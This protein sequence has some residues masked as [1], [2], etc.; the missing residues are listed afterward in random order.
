[1][2][3][4]ITPKY[5]FKSYESLIT[6]NTTLPNQP[7]ITDSSSYEPMMTDHSNKKNKMKLT[8]TSNITSKKLI[9]SKPNS[10]SSLYNESFDKTSKSFEK[11]I[12][13]IKHANSFHN[14]AVS[15]RYLEKATL[16]SDVKKLSTFMNLNRIESSTMTMLSKGIMREKDILQYK[17]NVSYLII[18][19]I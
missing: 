5:N 10:L 6:D 11:M 16:E 17:T 14:N 13:V 1:M 9:E 2:K 4:D 15:A 19:I 7:M 8:K 12:K 18:I 3:D